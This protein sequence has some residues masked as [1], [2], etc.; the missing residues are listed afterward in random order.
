MILYYLEAPHEICYEEATM[1]ALTICC[2]WRT[3]APEALIRIST[4]QLIHNGF[5][6]RSFILA[7]L[8]RYKY[9]FMV[10]K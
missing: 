2:H 4:D 1:S 9:I 7:S 10:A 8:I 6:S 5:N 3:L